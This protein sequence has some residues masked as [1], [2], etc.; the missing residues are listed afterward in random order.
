MRHITLLLTLFILVGCTSE[1]D[2][3]LTANTSTIEEIEQEHDIE[4]FQV[5]V[6][7]KQKD[8]DLV[9]RGEKPEM[10]SDYLW[11]NTIKKEF[12]RDITECFLVNN[13]EVDSYVDLEDDVW[14]L[15][16][17]LQ[18]GRV[19]DCVKDWREKELVRSQE[20]AEKICNRQGIY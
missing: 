13:R 3:C 17:G 18:E 14:G 2:K 1:R 5:L 15:P 11:G 16:I 12:G 10:G 9:K 6:R 8:L 19:Y 7:L 4:R 20:Q